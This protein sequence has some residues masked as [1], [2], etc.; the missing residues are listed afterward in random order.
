MQGY[1]EDSLRR[2]VAA[3]RLAEALATSSPDECFTAGLLQDFGLLALF[4][5]RPRLIPLW[6]EFR[7]ADPETRYRME[8]Q[9]FGATHD[10]I[11]ATLASAWALPEELRAALA[12]HHAPVGTDLSLAQQ[13]YVR[14]LSAN[15]HEL[16]MTFLWPQLPN[17]KL[18]NGRQ[19]F[20]ATIAGQI[21]RTNDL[22]F[23]QSQSFTNAP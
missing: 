1:W 5:A 15:L 16:R 17:G 21:A 8:Q 20:R 14:Q 13:Q 23:Y 19:T 18:G 2:A 9:E 3:R 4:F 11:G 10:E 6:P 7:C 12:Y 22:Y